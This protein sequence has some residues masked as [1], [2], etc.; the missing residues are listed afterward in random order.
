VQWLLL[1]PLAAELY[2][3]VLGLA[4]VCSTLYVWFRDVAQIW[5]VVVP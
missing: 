2:L 3:Y 1:I 5:E 4:L